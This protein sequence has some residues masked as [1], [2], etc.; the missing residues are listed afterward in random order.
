MTEDPINKRLTSTTRG[1]ASNFCLEGQGKTIIL[2][3]QWKTQSIVY[4]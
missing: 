2:I 1:V 3:F 4:L